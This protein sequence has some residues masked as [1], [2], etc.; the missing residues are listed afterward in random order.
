MERALP[1]LVMLPGLIVAA[2][3][4]LLAFGD[5]WRVWAG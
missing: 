5:I 1:W 4:L 2:L 3:Y